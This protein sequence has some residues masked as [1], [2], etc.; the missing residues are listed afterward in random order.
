[1]RKGRGQGDRGM[2]SWQVK[3]QRDGWLSEGVGSLFSTSFLAPLLHDL[4]SILEPQIHSLSPFSKPIL[5]T[6]SNCFL[7]A[8]KASTWLRSFPDSPHLLGRLV[9]FTVKVLSLQPY[10]S[11]KPDL[12]SL[13]SVEGNCPDISKTAD[14]RRFW[15]QKS[16]L[17]SVGELQGLWP[18]VWCQPPG[19]LSSKDVDSSLQHLLPII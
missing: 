5:K 1:M 14:L 8:G 2:E 16:T 12:R 7:I 18:M 9:S 17:D 6:G 10:Y 15:R 13:L 19:A 11:A 3:R 4:F